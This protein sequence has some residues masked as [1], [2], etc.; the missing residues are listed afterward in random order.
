VNRSGG[1]KLVPTAFRRVDLLREPPP[2][3]CVGG[4]VTIGNFDGVHRGHAAL[5]GAAARLAQAAGVPTVAITF[6]PPP[7]AILRPRAPYPPLT[8][9]PRRA[10]LLRDV[11]ADHVLVIRTH[12]QLLQLAPE[13]FFEQIL[14]RQLQ[15]RAVVEGPNFT[16]GK[17]RAGTTERLVRLCAQAHMDC[18][19]VPPVLEQGRPIS[20]SRVREA[21]LQGQPSLAATLLGRPYAVSGLVCR[22]AGRGR[23]L[24]FPTVNLGFIETLLPRAGVYACIAIT[25]TARYPAAVHVGPVPTFDQP[26]QR[27]EAH[28]VGFEGELLGEVVELRFVAWLRGIQRFESVEQLR[29]QVQSDVETCRKLLASGRY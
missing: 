26:E 14:R 23:R 24:G 22:G 29:R 5:I 11:G 7:A 9:M 4:V 13:V 1:D 10:R 28:L 17:D 19:I 2:T 27:V 12:R 20:S 8:T 21:L 25:P 3:E 16:F 18:L 6:D 15:A